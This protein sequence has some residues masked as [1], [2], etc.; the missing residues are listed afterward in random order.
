M[1]CLNSVNFRPWKALVSTAVLT[2]AVLLEIEPASLR[3]EP[4][5]AAAPAIVTPLNRELTALDRYVAQPDSS[6]EWKIVAHQTVP[7][8]DIYIIQ[9]TSQTWLTADE[10]DRPVWQHW[11][12]VVKPKGTTTN[13]ALM[14][15]GGGSNGGGR[16]PA[17]TGCCLKWPW[18]RNPSSPN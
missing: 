9:L 17:R 5:T 1:T 6:Y 13:K 4:A 15:I 16:R 8:G 11:L 12:T 7:Q 14:F 18:P 2:G 10:V 3:A